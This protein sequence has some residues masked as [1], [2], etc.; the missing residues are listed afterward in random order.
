MYTF[1]LFIISTA[2]PLLS[3]SLFPD[4]ILSF[5]SSHPTQKNFNN[6][7]LTY[8]TPWNLNGLNLYHLNKHKIDIASPVLYTI[9]STQNSYTI[10]GSDDLNIEG[11]PR[12]T[13]QSASL[14]LNEAGAI[15]KSHC[16]E[17][18][19]CK[20]VMIDGL[21]SIYNTWKKD[22]GKQ[23]QFLCKELKEIPI[24]FAVPPII[25]NSPISFIDSSM[26]YIGAN[27]PQFAIGINFYG[28]VHCKGKSPIVVDRKNY[29]EWL[30]LSFGMIRWHENEMEHTFIAQDCIVVYPTM[31]S[32]QKRIEFA[33]NNN[34]SIGIWE[35]GQGMDY[36]MDLF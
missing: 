24:V 11:Y 33:I 7:L 16:S 27:G 21:Y 1:L 22:F 36:F 5:Q 2:H 17:H 30:K 6:T 34:Y 19:N 13:F 35:L 10:T 29:H 20:G 12:Y 23:L 31:Y 15:I 4:S 9:S 18:S 28:Y 8:I 26:K 25:F 32:L 14:P 3:K